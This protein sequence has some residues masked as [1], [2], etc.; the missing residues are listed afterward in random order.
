MRSP[1]SRA[2]LTTDFATLVPAL[3]AARALAAFTPHAAAS[4]LLSAA[5]LAPLIASAAAI[6]SDLSFVRCHTLLSS[7]G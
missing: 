6:R 5:T 1:I 4:G 2:T 7:L 3:I